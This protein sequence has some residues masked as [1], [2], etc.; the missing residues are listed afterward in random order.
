MSKHLNR[1]HQSRL[2]LLLLH[3]QLMRRHHRRLNQNRYLLM[4]FHLKYLR[5][6][7]NHLDYLLLLRCQK[8]CHR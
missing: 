5:L 3:L 6:G 4:D 1:Y 7:N 8:Y 2:L